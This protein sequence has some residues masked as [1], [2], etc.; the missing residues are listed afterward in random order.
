MGNKCSLL[1]MKDPAGSKYL[2]YRQRLGKRLAGLIEEKGYPSVENFALSNGMHKATVHQ[3]LNAEADPRLSTLL[4][5]CD[6]L[7]VSPEQVIK[8]L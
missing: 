5:I 1:C 8:G 6:S 7:E 4:R 2:K 3:V